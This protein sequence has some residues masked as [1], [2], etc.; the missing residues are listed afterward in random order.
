MSVSDLSIAQQQVF[1]T[2]V[3]LREERSKSPPT[4]TTPRPR[5][6]V[7]AVDIGKIQAELLE[8]NLERQELEAWLSKF[9]PNT[10]GRTLAERKEKYMKEK[11]LKE[12][13]QSISEKRLAIR[14]AKIDKS[15]PM[16]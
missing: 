1:R 15:H 2:H 3:E 4:P 9:P 8:L 13:E 12:L 7:P 6:T 14:Q 5:D 10:A 11:R 16:G